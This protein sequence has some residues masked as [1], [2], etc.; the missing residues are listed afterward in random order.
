MVRN[1]K[2]NSSMWYYKGCGTERTITKTT[3]QTISR[4]SAAPVVNGYVEPWQPW[5]THNIYYHAM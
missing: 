4:F 3:I 1:D 5:W 2:K